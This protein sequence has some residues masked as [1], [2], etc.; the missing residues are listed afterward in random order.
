MTPDTIN[1]REIKF[2]ADLT[3]STGKK[4]TA[5]EPIDIG[6]NFKI[7]PISPASKTYYYPTKTEKTKIC[8]H[9]TVGVLPGDIASLTKENYHMSVSYVVDRRGNIYCLFDDSYWSYHLGSSAIGG[10]QV[11]SKASIG[12]EISNYG[13]LKLKDGKFIDAYGN[14]YS[15][16]LMDADSVS[17]RGYSYY[18]KMTSVQKK[19]VAHL[20]KYLSEKHGIPLEFK[21]YPSDVF[22][23]ANDAVAFKGIYTHA[24]VRSD[25]FDLPAEMT[26]QIKDTL[27]EIVKEPETVEEPVEETHAEPEKK[28]FIVEE[29][30]EGE[31]VV[32]EVDP[33]HAE[34]EQLPKSWYNRLLEWLK[35]LFSSDK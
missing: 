22:E 33:V 24:N 1:S 32:V 20:I 17:F 13:P 5:G 12:I 18:A 14:T 11:M 9:F 34:E 35:G 4:F 29:N 28:E 8:L 16:N 21:E 15:T 27:D 25:K 7:I 2:E 10:N 3:D 26:L 30:A 23:T 6:G 31:P 19:A